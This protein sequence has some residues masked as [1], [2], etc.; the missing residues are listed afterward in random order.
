M[1]SR[2]ALLCC[3]WSAPALA[4]AQQPPPTYAFPPAAPGI[5]TANDVEYAK[6]GDTTLAMDV[7]QPAGSSIRRPALVFF[8]R[9][10]GAD[11]KWDFYASWA[12]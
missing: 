4:S 6:S 5:T 9:A 8:N 7:Y 12:R 11:R 10:V 3:L 2:T 1:F